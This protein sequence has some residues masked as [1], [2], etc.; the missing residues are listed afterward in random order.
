MVSKEKERWL[1]LLL[2]SLV[3]SGVA[4]V[5]ADSTVHPARPVGRHQHDQKYIHPE[6][7]G[8]SHLRYDIHYVRFGYQQHI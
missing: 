2:S 3:F 7:F 5:T 4:A 1:C 6:D 8:Y